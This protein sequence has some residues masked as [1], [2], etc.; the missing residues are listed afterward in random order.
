MKRSKLLTSIAT[1]GGSML[2]ATN[3]F[4]VSVVDAGVATQV[5]DT[6]TDII[7]VGGLVIGLAVVAMG[8]RWVKATFF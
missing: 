5:A 8:I 3:A 2:A 6:Q 7:T 4:A 1:V